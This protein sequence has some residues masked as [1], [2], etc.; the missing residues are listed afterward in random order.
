VFVRICSKKND[1]KMVKKLFF[2]NVHGEDAKEVDL[3]KC[4]RM[5]II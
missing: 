3:G 1:D 4:G 2:E 5:M